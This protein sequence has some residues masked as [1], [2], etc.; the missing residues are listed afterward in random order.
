MH[1]SDSVRRLTIPC[2]RSIP[3]QAKEIARFSTSLIPPLQRPHHAQGPAYS[4]FVPQD[5]AYREGTT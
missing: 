5:N 4:A 1:T 3:A 2:W